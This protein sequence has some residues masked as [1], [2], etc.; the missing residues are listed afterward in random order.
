MHEY[1]MSSEDVMS[2]AQEAKLAADRE[3]QRLLARDRTLNRQQPYKYGHALRAWDAHSNDTGTRTQSDNPT[4]R[5]RDR[6]YQ[7]QVGSTVSSSIHNRAGDQ[8]DLIVRER[9][10]GINKSKNEY[11]HEL[12]S[13]KSDHLKEPPYRRF[14][15]TDDHRPELTSR[16]YQHSKPLPRSQTHSNSDVMQQE[17]EV[18]RAQ[19][20]ASEVELNRFRET[21]SDMTHRPH[22]RHPPPPPRLLSMPPPLQQ[23]YDPNEEARHSA[24]IASIEDA[25]RAAAH[26]SQNAIDLLEEENVRLAEA[27]NS[28]ELA[29]DKQRIESIQLKNEIS[30]MSRENTKSLREAQ[31]ECE[32]KDRLSQR[33]L[34]ELHETQAALHSARKQLKKSEQM[35]ANTESELMSA[36]ADYETEVS[37]NKSMTEKL[38]L[39][40]DKKIELEKQVGHEKRLRKKASKNVSVLVEIIAEMQDH[41]GKANQLRKDCSARGYF[42]TRSQKVHDIFA[43][44]IEK[45]ILLATEIKDGQVRKDILTRIDKIRNG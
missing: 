26:E 28:S 35:G 23:T 11:N 19:V 7:S 38:A 40:T 22:I 9:L 45:L 25:K 30:D 2:L 34:S 29:W 37:C 43:S 14:T 24:H 3:V 39:I 15:N 36:R 20:A 1:Q 31:I 13:M 41:L 33:L 16:A 5:D 27:K 8:L 12:L 32:A 6:D 21:M 42:A 44:S 4:D 10:R 18:A 17:L